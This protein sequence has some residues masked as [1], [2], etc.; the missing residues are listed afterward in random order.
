MRE[1]G[2]IV[3]V[4]GGNVDSDGATPLLGPPMTANNG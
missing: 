4:G 3:C 2:D 1:G